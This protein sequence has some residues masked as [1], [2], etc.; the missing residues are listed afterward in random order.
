MI[1]Y[2]HPLYAQSLTEFGEP[3]ELT[4]SRTWL[5]AKP[6][7][8]SACRDGM[9]CYPLFCC[10]DWSKLSGDLDALAE[11]LLTIS[12]VLDPFAPLSPHDLDRCFNIVRPFKQH[13]VIDLDGA[14]EA[15]IS[16]HH[17][18]YARKALQ[19][20]RV[21]LA[22]EPASHLDEWFSFYSRLVERHKLR[23]IKAFSRHAFAVQLRVPGLMMFRALI[24]EQAVG[25]HLWFIQNGVAYSHL[26][27]YSEEGYGLGAAY[28]LYWEA[29]RK[30]QS[31]MRDLVRWI[32][33]GAGAG[34][35]PV[36]TN[37]L[38]QFK[39][40]WSKTTRTKYFCGRICNSAAYADINRA[41]GVS[42]TGYFPAYRV[43]EF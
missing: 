4:N 11:R 2:A 17:R 30:F 25:A 41:A 16:K 40:G 27:A 12:I 13:F 8:Q 29:I 22:A 20:V 23:G 43:G 35:S 1:G 21:E 24:G 42:D 28:A 36:E 33:L 10:G 19:Q 9:S 7:P 26:A 38:T 39:S 18:Y 6:V 15:H 34:A 31:E 32:D 37:G 3:L 14:V 5:L